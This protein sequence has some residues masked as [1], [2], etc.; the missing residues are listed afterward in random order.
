MS[1]VFQNHYNY[2]LRKCTKLEKLK[3]G[4]L[5]F[6]DMIFLDYMPQLEELVF[7]GVNES[8]DSIG[9]GRIQVFQNLKNLYLCNGLTN[10]DPIIL[11]PYFPKAGMQ[12]ANDLANNHFMNLLYQL[13]C[14]QI[15]TN[16]VRINESYTKTVR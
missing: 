12:M 4:V 9:T 6:V 2:L 15:I 14:H 11:K 16:N 8:L 7:L 10:F 1:G 5:G 3:I 13:R